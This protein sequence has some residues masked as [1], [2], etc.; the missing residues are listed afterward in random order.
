L[1]AKNCDASDTCWLMDDADAAV[2]GCEACDDEVDRGDA[3]DAETVKEV[4][5]QL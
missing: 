3:T 5:S 1:E 2:A 4:S